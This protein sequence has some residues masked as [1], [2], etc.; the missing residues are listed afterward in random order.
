MLAAADGQEVFNARGCV[1][2]AGLDQNTLWSM[3]APEVSNA[4]SW[5]TVAGLNQKTLW[6]MPASDERV[7]ESRRLFSTAWSSFDEQTDAYC[8]GLGT[9]MKVNGS[10]VLPT[11]SFCQYSSAAFPA[12]SGAARVQPSV[13]IGPFHLQ[14]MTR[15]FACGGIHCGWSQPALDATTC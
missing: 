11:F 12:L 8:A 7:R 5:M 9:G 13:L 1:I 14:L 3:P 10:R 4:R 15:L 6:S 2:V